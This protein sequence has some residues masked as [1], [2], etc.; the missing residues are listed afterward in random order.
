MCAAKAGLSAVRRNR[1]DPGARD[2]FAVRVVDNFSQSVFKTHGDT[3]LLEAQEYDDTDLFTNKSSA[4]GFEDSVQLHQRRGWLALPGA[5]KPSL[6]VRPLV[7]ASA[8]V[9]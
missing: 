7:G 4:W 1:C 8:L 5:L 6:E 2:A 9:C 3:A